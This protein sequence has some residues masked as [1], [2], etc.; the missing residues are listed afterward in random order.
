LEKV[1]IP[2]GGGANTHPTTKKEHSFIIENNDGNN[3]ICNNPTVTVN[4]IV[5]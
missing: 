4:I 2:F 3:F 1:K 5:F